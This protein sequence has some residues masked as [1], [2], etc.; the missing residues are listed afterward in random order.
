MSDITEEDVSKIIIFKTNKDKI[1]EL[2]LN[3]ITFLDQC[4]YKSQSIDERENIKVALEM[5]EN[6]LKIQRYT[7]KHLSDI[8]YKETR[9][10]IYHTIKPTANN[11]EREA[12]Q[13]E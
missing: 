3:E 4:F 7:E 11:L 12:F 1:I 5:L 6:L 13:D 8:D 2:L 10:F 9:E